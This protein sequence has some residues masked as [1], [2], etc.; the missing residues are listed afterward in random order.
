MADLPNQM[1]RNQS[2]AEKVI[3]PPIMKIGLEDSYIMRKIHKSYL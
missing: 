1:K 2:K 3:I